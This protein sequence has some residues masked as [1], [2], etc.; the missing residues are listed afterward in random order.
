[1]AV[2]LATLSLQH[3]GADRTILLVVAES[4][5]LLAI[6]R[7]AVTSI[8][9]VWMVNSFLGWIVGKATFGRLLL[10]PSFAGMD[11]L[12]TMAFLVSRSAFAFRSGSQPRVP[13]WIILTAIGV[14]VVLTWHFAYLISLTLADDLVNNLP[15]REPTAN[16][17]EYPPYPGPYQRLLPILV[18]W[19]MPALAALIHLAI[20]AT[21]LYWFP[22]VSA[23]PN[24]ARTPTVYPRRRKFAVLIAAASVVAAA[25]PV[26]AT[27]CNHRPDLTGKKFVVYEK[28][29]LN[30]ERPSHGDYGR[31]SIGMYGMLPTYIESLGATCLISQELSAED[32]AGADV[33][34]LL[35]PDAAWEDQ[36]LDRIQRFVEHGGS[37]LIFGEHT[38]AEEDRDGKKNGPRFNDVLRDS[39]MRVRFDSAMF[40]VGGGYTR[41][42]HYH[43]RPTPV[44]RMKKTNSASSSGRRSRP[45]GRLDRFS[46]DVGVGP[47][48]V[49]RKMRPRTWETIVTTMENDWE[50]SSWPPSSKWVRAGLLSSATRQVLRMD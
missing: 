4:I 43:I 24:S 40:A 27:L 25:L 3:E 28:G 10:G 47:I 31:L 48:P 15:E 29:F 42:R 18:P 37:L 45:A 34:I 22:R 36:Q 38:V 41:M 19:N 26:A 5:V 11:F 50:T 49:T 6:F 2:V 1:V 46:S 8:P 33:V 16:S 44:S 32:V 20:A 23:V 35:F 12:V 13:R 39:A 14:V 30:F 21:V 7:F 9:L 17:F